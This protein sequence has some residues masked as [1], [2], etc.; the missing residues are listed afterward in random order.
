MKPTSIKIIKGLLI[1]RLI[2]TGIIVV[3]FFFI[4]DLDSSQRTFWTGLKNGIIASL[5]LDSEN[6]NTIFGYLIGSILIPVILGLLQIKFVNERKYKA[7]L[8]TVIF[9]LIFGLSQGFSLFPII[10]LILI[11]TQPTKNYLK[12]KEETQSA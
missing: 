4:K 9:D 10:I 11:L 12:N 3:V 5:H 1:F 8:I 7:M 2:L 6:T